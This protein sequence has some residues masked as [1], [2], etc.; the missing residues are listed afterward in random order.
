MKTFFFRR[1]KVFV[2]LLLVIV[3]SAIWQSRLASLTVDEVKAGLPVAVV[4][5]DDDTPTDLSAVC[6][7]LLPDSGW[8]IFIVDVSLVS[9]DKFR[10]YFETSP[11][12]QGVFLEYDP[13]ERA[14]FRIGLGI[15]DD[16][17]LSRIRTVRYEESAVIL[18]GLRQNE[19]RVI[20]NAVD[21]RFHVPRSPQA[22][23]RCDAVRVGLAD[24]VDCGNCD[25]SVH[26]ATG[27]NWQ[28]Y[29]SVMN[30]VSNVANF[31]T[32]RLLGTAL[33]IIGFVLLMT[34]MRL[35]NRRRSVSDTSSSIDAV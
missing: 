29:E 31:N 12:S 27:S 9:D 18:I 26:Y 19:A 35:K 30:Q 33:T 10:G 23:F 32:R 17:Q 3:G 16:V 6:S 34:P 20:M 15:G 8:I 14:N 28:Q 22:G 25:I 24:G 2:S 13:G 5:I 7:Q 1:A 4:R 21:Y 11:K